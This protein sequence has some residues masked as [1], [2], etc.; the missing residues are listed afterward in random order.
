[1]Q[2]ILDCRVIKGGRRASWLFQ[3][4]KGVLDRFGMYNTTFRQLLDA[5]WE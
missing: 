1:M 5:A 2:R 3:N 4:N